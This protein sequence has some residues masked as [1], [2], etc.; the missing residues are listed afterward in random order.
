MNPYRVWP[1]PPTMNDSPTTAIAV[2][3]KCSVM[4]QWKYP[5]R[6]LMKPLRQEKES[7]GAAGDT[8]LTAEDLKAL[9]EDYKQIIRREF[10]EEFPQDPVEQLKFAIKAVLNLGIT[11]A[12]AST[13]VCI[14]F[15]T[16][17]AQPSMCRPWSSAIWRY[18]RYWRC[19]H[20]KSCD[21]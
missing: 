4:S 9:V 1:A 2:L 7:V 12:P 10:G 17:W 11:I 6:I 13:A 3:F 8:D 15:P 16:I 5:S 20:Q 14:I 18:I 21:R 19:I